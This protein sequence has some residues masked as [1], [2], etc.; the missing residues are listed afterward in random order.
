MTIRDAIARGVPVA[1]LVLGALVAVGVAL[2]HAVTESAMPSPATSAAL[3]PAVADAHP[4]RVGV[5]HGR[6]TTRDGAVREGRLRWGSGAEEAFWSDAF[7]G[8]KDDN[9]WAVLVPPER[10]P[11]ERA[12]FE[13]FGIKIGR[14]RPSVLGRPFMAR[15]G[16]IA[17]IE[18]LG[19]DVRVTLKSGTTFNLD[20]TSSS[21]FD[22]TVRV[23][24]GTGGV[25]DLDPMQVTSI[26]LL[27]GAAKGPS[28]ERLH[29]TVLTPH[30]AFTGSLQWGRERGAA[31]DELRGHAADG[32][33]ALRFDSIRSIVRGSA[34]DCVVTLLD[35]REIMLTGGPDIG[36][37]S[38]GTYVDDRRYGRVLISWDAFKR[39]DFSAGGDGPAYDDFPP[40]RPLTGVVV[41]RGGRRLA[42]RIVYDLDE[43]ETTETLDAPAQGVDYTILFGLIASIVPPGRDER[44]AR[45]AR[46]TLHSGEELA[47]EG[48]GDLG[49]SNAG[50]LVFIDD[51]QPPEYVAWPDVEEIALD[52]PTAMYPPLDGGDE[53][54]PHAE[55]GR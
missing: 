16:D 20:R 3:P 37:D 46:V 10:L 18:P 35:G 21:D 4:P 44:G 38:R 55:P 7:N 28:P 9:P 17:R 48:A 45:S 40:G 30:G 47:L 53:D 24:D 33:V 12:R 2:R 41:V 11:S 27:P 6:V 51:K 29:G 50:V 15:F 23:W 19:L 34:D 42:G 39:V 31:S 14:R 32:E 54:A 25:V 8:F 5:I 36:R 43:S 1:L 49:D 52:R 13:I 26:E 22:D